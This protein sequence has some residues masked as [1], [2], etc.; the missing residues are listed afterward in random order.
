M[1]SGE[2][3][4]YENEKPVVQEVRWGVGRGGCKRSKAEVDRP[5]ISESEEW[6]YGGN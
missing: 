1:T 2:Y 6:S 4:F 3:L 5:G